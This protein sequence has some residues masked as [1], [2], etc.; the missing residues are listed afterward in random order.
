[1]PLSFATLGGSRKRA[2]RRV[3][4]SCSVLRGHADRNASGCIGQRLITRYQQ[5]LSQ[6]KPHTPRPRIER[7]SKDSGVA[8]SQDAEGEAGP[9]MLPAGHGASNGHG[10]AHEVGVWMEPTT[11]PIPH[12][13]RLWS[14]VGATLQ[15]LRTPTT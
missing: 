3:H 11:S 13:L 14:R 5:N 10:T 12:Q 7:G 1:M 9:S 8:C 6:E 4:L 2:T 15:V